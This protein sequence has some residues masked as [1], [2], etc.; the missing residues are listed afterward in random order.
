MPIANFDPQTG[1]VT[2][3]NGAL[4]LSI[5]TQPCYNPR[6][7][8]DRDSGRSLADSDYVWADGA[9]AELLGQPVLTSA[10][11]GT[12][13]AT[14]RARKGVLEIEHTFRLPAAEPN[15]VLELI[16]LRNPG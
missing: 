16:T 1:A 6:R 12:V 13:T 7:L 10:A 14:F 15:V 2:L 9:P 3:V 11:D 4:E 8:R 5:E